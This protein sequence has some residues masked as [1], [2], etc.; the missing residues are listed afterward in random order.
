[1]TEEIIDESLFVLENISRFGFAVTTSEP[2]NGCEY[3]PV[4]PPERFEGPFNNTLNNPILI[5][6]NTVSASWR[7]HMWVELIATSMS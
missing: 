2:D 4:T 7:P 6:S 3:W 5:V 1:M